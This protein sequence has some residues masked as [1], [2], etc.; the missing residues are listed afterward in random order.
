MTLLP[1]PPSQSITKMS[2]SN[3]SSD[4]EE[5]L[6][7]DETKFLNLLIKQVISGNTNQ[8]KNLI[9][10]YYDNNH[11]QNQNRD[12]F[13]KTLVNT[14]DDLDKLMINYAISNGQLSTVK[15]LVEN[16]KADIHKKTHIEFII[17]DFVSP[18]FYAIIYTH[19]IKN[20]NTIF[21]IIEYLLNNGANIDDKSY[22]H[23][24]TPLMIACDGRLTYDKRCINNQLK[25][26]KFL[27][28]RCKAN[29]NMK[30]YKGRTCLMLAYINSNYEIINY[31]ENF[32]GADINETCNNGFT[33]KE[34]GYCKP[35][36]I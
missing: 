28:E 36:D 5:Y 30:N 29:V 7:Y 24:Y 17:D 10:T 13:I 1:P 8:F 19:K 31:L 2:S 18:I 27:V 35:F 11:I 22:Y 9:N 33:A 25:L 26:I 14:H 21:D 20:Y 15:Y 3:S 23:Q 34:Y 12:E 4:D 32:A 16:C 6:Q